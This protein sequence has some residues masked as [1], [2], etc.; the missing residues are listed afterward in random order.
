MQHLPA[1]KGRWRSHPSWPVFLLGA[2]TPNVWLARAA[3]RYSRA[4]LRTKWIILWPALSLRPEKLSPKKSGLYI[5]HLHCRLVFTKG[6]P[7][8]HK[9]KIMVSMAVCALQIFTPILAISDSGLRPHTALHHL[10]KAKKLEIT[11]QPLT[12]IKKNVFFSIP[13][14]PI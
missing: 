11:E 7:P 5:S 10:I 6:V 12:A 9:K 8:L 2:Q 4:F 13:E 14:G 3:W 1:N